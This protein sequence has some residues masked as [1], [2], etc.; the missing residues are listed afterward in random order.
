MKHYQLIACIILAACGLPT[1]GADIRIHCHGQ[2]PLVYLIGGGPALTT[3]N[4]QPIQEHL[5]NDYR[6]CRRDM[7]G[8]GDNAGVRVA[9]RM[10]VLSQWLLDMHVILP[11]EQV[12]LWGVFMGCP[13]GIAVCKRIP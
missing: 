10:P 6:V 9:S 8:V 3:W 7:R 5:G 13:A 12:V 1:A 11:Q 2:G 4:L